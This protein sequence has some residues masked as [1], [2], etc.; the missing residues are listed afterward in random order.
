MR[1][2][3][4][5]LR[6][7]IGS[8]VAGMRYWVEVR[9]KQLNKYQRV[10]GAT[11]RE[12]H[13]RADMKIAQWNEQYERKSVLEQ[14]R[15]QG[16]AK[17]ELNDLQKIE[18]QTQTTEASLRIEEIESMLLNVIDHLKSNPIRSLRKT[19]NFSERA[20][21]PAARAK[22][23]LER[24]RS[25]PK[26]NPKLG[27]ITRLLPFLKNA[28][29]RES[30]QVFAEDRLAWRSVYEKIAESNEI[31]QKV[32]SEQLARWQASKADCERHNSDF[33]ANFNDFLE[34]VRSREPKAVIEYFSHILDSIDWPEALEIGFSVDFSP[35]TGTL[36]INCEMPSVEDIPNV[37]FIRYIASREEIE[38]VKLKQETI[39]N[40]YDSAIY[41]IMLCAIYSAF[42]FDDFIILSSIAVNS[43]VSYVSKATGTD[44]VACIASVLTTKEQFEQLHLRRVDAKNC[45]RHLKG[46]ANARI[47]ELVPVRPVLE[48]NKHDKRFVSSVSVVG[49]IDIGVNLA[50]L[51]WEE[52]EHLVREIFE[53]EFSQNG[54]EV[55]GL[56]R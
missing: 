18:A 8:G 14:R 31:A 49:G 5:A 47:H 16:W 37:K 30:D 56:F 2:G 55:R 35:D 40:L 52:F 42:K 48:I 32:F 29:I 51:G 24:Q 6:T 34:E 13:Q 45:F 15:R 25:D 4:L 41:Q 28:K 10:H 21:T 9:H 44:E 26:Y 19:I 12:A 50:T 33:L 23:P 36:C 54:G 27:L 17:R 46:I 53:K 3:S 20:P 7:N 1:Y 39:N 22:Y 38:I 43:W 11:P